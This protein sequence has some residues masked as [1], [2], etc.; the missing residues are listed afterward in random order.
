MVGLLG[1]VAGMI[2]AFHGL[3]DSDPVS[4]NAVLADG[5]WRALLTT[6]GGW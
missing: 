3:A 2:S 1:T 5:I 4:R 6:A